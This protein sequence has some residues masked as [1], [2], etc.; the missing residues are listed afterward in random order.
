VLEFQHHYTLVL[1]MET[2]G[3]AHAR[4]AL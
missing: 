2:R 4:P 1:S 3:F